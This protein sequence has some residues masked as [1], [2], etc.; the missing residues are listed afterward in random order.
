MLLTAP[1]LLLVVAALAAAV[2]VPLFRA[3]PDS[4]WRARFLRRAGFGLVVGVAGFF[5]LFVVGETFTDPGGWRAV[6]LVATWSVPLALS[7]LVAWRWPD[8]GTWL[9]GALTAALLAWDV[10]FALDP[11]LWRGIEDRNGPLHAIA[12]LA[13]ATAVAVLGLKRSRTAG[14]LLLLVSGGSLLALGAGAGGAAVLTILT[15]PVL[16]AGVLFLLAAHLGSRPPSG[17]PGGQ[18]TGPRP[19]QLQ[20]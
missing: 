10:W 13:L 12:T 8:G 6:V 11:T 4:A 16:L 7:C 3:H 17:P 14:V 2:A 5:G 15:S 20:A 19:D 18:E 1:L 9:L